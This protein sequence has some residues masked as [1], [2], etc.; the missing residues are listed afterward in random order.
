MPCATSLLRQTVSKAN[1]TGLLC[2]QFINRYLYYNIILIYLKEVF[3]R[4][5]DLLSISVYLIIY[6]CPG[7]WQC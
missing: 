3:E 4:T 1:Y 5:V 7:C 6:L 2:N